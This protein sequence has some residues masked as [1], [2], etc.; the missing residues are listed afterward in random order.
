[1]GKIIH[2]WQ[3]HNRYA[4][5]PCSSDTEFEDYLRPH[6]QS[7]FRLSVRWCGNTDDAEDLLQAL[8]CKLYPIRNQFKT[9]HELR[10]WLV[11]VLYRQFV[12]GVRLKNRQPLNFSDTSLS[13]NEDYEQQT[14]IASGT[15]IEQP[16][17]VFEAGVL[18]QRLQTA[19][20]QMPASRRALII[21][22]DVE[23]Y[24]LEEISLAMDI[25]VG[26]VKSR[27]HRTRER[28]RELLLNQ[29]GTF[30]QAPAYT[31]LRTEK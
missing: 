28:L 12:D 13:S 19:L 8:F 2:L 25:P 23:S 30:S 1:M 21:M 11:R 9:I 20:N 10:P 14:P 16:E 26:T 22:H 27:L 31:V 6:I 29:D 7:L 24:S 4:G 15:P 5:R 18:T 17:T 3:W